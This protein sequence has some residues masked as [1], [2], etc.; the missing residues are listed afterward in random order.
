MSHPRAV[1]PLQLALSDALLLTLKTAD[2]VQVVLGD[3]ARIFDA[4]A[5]AGFVP[6]VVLERHEMTPLV[7]SEIPTEEHIFTLASRSQFGGIVE[8]KAILN[9]LRTAVEDGEIV[10]DRYRVVLAHVTYSD[11]MRARDYRTFRGVI[12]IRIIVE[13]PL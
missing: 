9:A 5:A 10:L 2:C 6:Y 3:P 8:A 13:G 7:T 11:V 12:R 4:E 1:V